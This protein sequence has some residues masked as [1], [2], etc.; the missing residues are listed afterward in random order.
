MG[1][2]GDHALNALRV[3]ARVEG[4]GVGVEAVGFGWRAHP[5]IT[6]S[7]YSGKYLVPYGELKHSCQDNMFDHDPAGTGGALRGR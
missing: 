2:T 5:V 4:L 1:S 7:A 3:S 6:L